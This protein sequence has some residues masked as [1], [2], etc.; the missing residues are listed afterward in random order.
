MAAILRA[1]SARITHACG[2]SVGLFEA[3]MRITSSSRR[4]GLPASSLS[5]ILDFLEDLSPSRSDS[6]ARPGPERFHMD[7]ERKPL[8]QF[9]IALFMAAF[10]D[11]NPDPPQS[12][13]RKTACKYSNFPAANNNAPARKRLSNWPV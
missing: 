11:R 2:I 3:S 6:Q 1:R 12:G 13:S 9:F 10:S 7:R 4:I 8:Q 5:S